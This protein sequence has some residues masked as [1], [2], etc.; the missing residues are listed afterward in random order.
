MVG[1]EMGL[2]DL[3]EIILCRA[4]HDCAAS[5]PETLGHTTALEY[6]RPHLRTR[7]V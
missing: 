4:T 1:A 6:E 2:N 5:S 7:D 3:V